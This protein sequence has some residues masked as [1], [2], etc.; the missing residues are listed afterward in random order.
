[1]FFRYQKTAPERCLHALL[2]K[3]ANAKYLGGRFYSDEVVSGMVEKK[4]QS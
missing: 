2:A 1:M 4:R 3:Q